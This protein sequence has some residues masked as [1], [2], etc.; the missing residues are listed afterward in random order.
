[1]IKYARTST[2]NN[3]STLFIV[4]KSGQNQINEETE[5]NGVWFPED[6]DSWSKYRMDG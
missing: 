2:R 4:F 1:M 6:S 5:W 3:D